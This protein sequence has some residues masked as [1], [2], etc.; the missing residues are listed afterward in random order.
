MPL[1]PEH[2]A[3][4]LVRRPERE[5]GER[6]LEHNSGEAEN[7]YRQLKRRGI[8]VRVGIEACGHTGW[9]ERRLAELEIDL[10]IGNPAKIAVQR[11][12]NR[13]RKL[14]VPSP[15]NRDLRQLLW[16]SHRLVPMRTRVKNQWQATALNE[17]VQ[18][19]SR[20]WSK[21]GRAQLEWFALAPWA[22][23]RREDLRRLLDP[24]TPQVAEL[25]QAVEREAERR[26]K[27]RRMME[28]PG[29]GPITALACRPSRAL[30]QVE[31]LWKS[32]PHPEIFGGPAKFAGV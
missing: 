31:Y 10:W 30:L 24:L 7:F 18:R 23:R 29:V 16:H 28:H 3:N 21:P 14:W 20:R 11:L 25:S 32:T 22:A 15:E 4:R 12:E 13:F 17:G 19:R 27:V 26:P 1:S 9:F 6:R 2:A 5:R 8:Q